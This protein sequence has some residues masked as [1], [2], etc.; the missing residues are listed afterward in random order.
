MFLDTTSRLRTDNTDS[1]E[2]KSQKA[3]EVVS[4]STSEAD[5]G[6]ADQ[7]KPSQ[8]KSFTP[9]EENLLHSLL[10]RYPRGKM[11]TFDQ[12][13]NLSSS[14]EDALSPRGPI[15]SESSR[16][17]R[18]NRKQIEAMLLQRHFPGVRQLLF[19]GLWDAGSSR[20]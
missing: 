8:L 13:G 7:S 2:R 3:A 1:H 11:W 20:W 9:V 12:D 14:D 19:T 15:R 10:A 4:Y 6:L 5:L 16:Q 18:V 17:S